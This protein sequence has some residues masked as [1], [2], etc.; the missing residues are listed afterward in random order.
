MRLV[1]MRLVP[2]RLVP[3]RLV[4]MRLRWPDQRHKV[5]E[6]SAP[7]RHCRDNATQM[8]RPSQ[9][10]TFSLT[11]VDIGERAA[12]EV[13]GS[14]SRQRVVIG[15]HQPPSQTPIPWTTPIG[16]NAAAAISKCR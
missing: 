10:A 3:M 4:P 15:S 1:P 5:P 11:L 16:K 13:P 6:A 7:T 12:A 2:M 9:R 14:D 8:T